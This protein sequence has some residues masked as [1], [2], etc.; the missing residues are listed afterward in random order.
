MKD[1]D[2]CGGLHFGSIGC[3]FLCTVCQRDIRPDASPRC[4]C[5]VVCVNGCRGVCNGHFWQKRRE[6]ATA[7]VENLRAEVE[8][9]K[10]E[11]QSLRERESAEDAWNRA[12]SSAYYAIKRGEIYLQPYVAPTK[13][14]QERPL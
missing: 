7:E 3:P 5:P 13:L 11:L 2:F 6:A 10:S 12:W 14:E 9:L 4:E 8:S 1:C